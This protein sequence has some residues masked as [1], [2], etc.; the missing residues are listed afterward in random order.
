MLLSRPPSKVK[1]GP[2]KVEWDRM[3]SETETELTP[4]TSSE[5][6]QSVR[7][8]LASEASKAPAVAVLEA[9]ATVERTRTART[10]LRRSAGAVSGRG[11]RWSWRSTREIPPEAGQSNDTA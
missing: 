2:F 5:V 1:A 4:A 10:P 7:A 9:H 11:H 3:V 6:P 8:E